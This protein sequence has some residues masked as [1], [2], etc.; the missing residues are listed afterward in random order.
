MEN[1]KANACEEENE[2]LR[3][4]FKLLAEKSKDSHTAASLAALSEQMV[5]IYLA[6]K[7]C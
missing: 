6:L 4:Q 7:L 2:L 3:K 5:K 1:K